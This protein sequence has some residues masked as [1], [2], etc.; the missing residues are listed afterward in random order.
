MA[1]PTLTSDTVASS[2]DP[3]AT[4]AKARTAPR[5]AAAP[6]SM[7]TATR[8]GILGAIVAA[9]LVALPAMASVSPNHEFA[10][11]HAVY[12]AARD[13]LEDFSSG[14][15]DRTEASYYAAIAAITPELASWNDGFG[16]IYKMRSDDH[17]DLAVARVALRYN[18]K[19]DYISEDF[20][21][22]CRAIVSAADYSAAE[23]ERL[24]HSTGYVRAERRQSELST[25]HSDATRAVVAYPVSTIRDLLVKMEIVGT[26]DWIADEG[27]HQHIIAD[28]RRLGGC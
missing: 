16:N 22:A 4:R 24:K 21:P 10:R 12:V 14:E 23:R 11:A 27:I 9:P 8:R 25:L 28:V 26:E 6:G 3:T 20:E 2:E 5:L 19:A 17:S 18:T 1:T 7:A 15:Y 13:E